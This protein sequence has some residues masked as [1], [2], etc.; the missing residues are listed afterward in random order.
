MGCGKYKLFES[1][2]KRFSRYIFIH[3]VSLA[4]LTVA[5]YS[6]QILYPAA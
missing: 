2:E 4:P 3:T 5:I 1:P 6:N